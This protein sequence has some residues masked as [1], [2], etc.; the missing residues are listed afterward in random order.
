[1]TLHSRSMRAF[2]TA[3]CACVALMICPRANSQVSNQQEQNA[4]PT[5][6]AP[7]SDSAYP[8]E[9]QPSWPDRLWAYRDFIDQIGSED[10]TRKR[11]IEEGKELL[12]PIFDY[13]RYWNMRKDEEQ[14]MRAILIDAY[15]RVKENDRQAMEA[16]NEAHRN[17]SAEAAARR[18]ALVQS[19]PK[20]Y[21]E[22]VAKLRHEL[23]KKNLQ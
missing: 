13:S 7:A 2:L 15:I 19:R 23:G 3:V 14:T 22:A 12:T 8:D 4:Q 11:A 1:M 17:N 9:V 5:Q 18:D 20:I 16:N 21:L 10:G 6:Q